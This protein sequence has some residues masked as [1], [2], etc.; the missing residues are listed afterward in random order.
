MRMTRVIFYKENLISNIESIRSVLENKKTK[1][2]IPVKANGYGAGA[3]FTAKTALEAGV[4]FFAVAT[5][6]E[7][8]EL[9]KAGIQD[10]EILLLSLCSESEME[11][12]VSFDLSPLVS[13]AEYISLFEK[14]AHRAQ[15]KL[16]VHLAIDTG[17]TRIGCFPEE[18]SALSKKISESG[19]LFLRG[20][21]THFSAADEQ[22]ENAKAFTD[23]QF[24][25]FTHAVSE[26]EKAGI[27]PGIRH[28]SA[29]AA[30]LVQ[31]KM[32]LDM[33]RP[34]LMCYG[35]FDG[36]ANE[37]WCKKNNV[38]LELKPVLA[39]ATKVASIRKIPKGNFVSYNRT[40]Q[41]NKDVYIATLPIGYADG[42]LRTLS[43][44]LCVTINSNSYPIV[45]RICM[46]QCMV[47]LG[48]N[49]ANVKRFDDV[50]IFGPNNSGAL[51]SA[52][53]LANIAGTIS[54]EI[55]TG[56]SHRVP[57]ILL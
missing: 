5:V 44:R 4:N 52:E 17:M 25:K 12:A 38:R 15:K 11:S 7:G 48:K 35:Y 18:A 14:A 43:P 24:Q 37:A 23:T 51:Q 16:N 40:W 56:I 9:R 32:Q 49:E 39:L 22:N 19:N 29:S 31:K 3:I 10:A 46:D 36:E 27:D 45:G 21:C 41:T 20:V 50:F 57:R 30:A 54:Y 47:A 1:I 34:G 28:C 6:D 26:I 53:K 42:L 55:L 33:V 2:C 13:D 8:I